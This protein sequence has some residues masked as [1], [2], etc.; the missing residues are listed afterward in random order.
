MLLPCFIIVISGDTF[1]YGVKVTSVSIMC[2]FLVNV[3]MNCWCLL[4]A[5]SAFMMIVWDNLVWVYTDFEVCFVA[6]RMISVCFPLENCFKLH[7]DDSIY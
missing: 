1:Y 3:S 5:S 7:I 2:I 4:E 6:L